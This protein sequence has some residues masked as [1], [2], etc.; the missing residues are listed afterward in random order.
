MSIKKNIKIWFN[1]LRKKGKPSCYILSKNNIQVYANDY[2]QI[3]LNIKGTNN[4]VSIPAIKGNGKITI[5]I[6]GNYNK[7][8]IKEGLV[9]S[10]HLHIVLGQQ[11]PHFGEITDS[12]LCIGENT[13]I[14]SMQY[15]TYNSHT[16][17]SI[18]R[19]CMIS[20]GVTLYNTDAHPIF[21][22]TSHK[23]VNHITGIKGGE[24][25]WLGMHSTVLKNST[26]PEDSILGCHSVYA[27][28]ATTAH[29]IWAGNPAKKIKE[30]IT[31]DKNGAIC[32]YI[33]NSQEQ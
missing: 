11:H 21:E 25:C 17:C 31:W 27:K 6:C 10:G 33:D 26:L 18:G 28:K 8:E 19:N 12:S 14:E 32:G 7:I 29:C 23:I 24:H 30:N 20:Y 22:K 13:S 4:T 2:S 3:K 1:K 15:I 9:L 5:D 16:V